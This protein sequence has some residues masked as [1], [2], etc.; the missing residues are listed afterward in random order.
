M[1]IGK[2]LTK[3][4]QGKI[5]ALMSENFTVREIAAKIKRSATVVHNYLKLKKEYGLK[6]NRG[7]K[8]VISKLLKKKIINFA[9]KKLMSSAKIKSKLQLDI[10]VR[11]IQR[12]LSSSPSVVYS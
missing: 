2:R 12:T 10:S 4:E 7:R 9:C 3:K 5:E 6:G 11:T 1:S 8:K